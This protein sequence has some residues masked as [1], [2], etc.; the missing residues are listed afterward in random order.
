M[1]RNECS[2]QRLTAAAPAYRMAMAILMLCA[3]CSP[4]NESNDHGRAAASTPINLEQPMASEKDDSELSKPTAQ[5][6]PSGKLT[7]G[8]AQRLR[9]ARPDTRLAVIVE[10]VTARPKV[11][12]EPHKRDGGTSIRPKS[13]L[14]DAESTTAAGFDKAVAYF[15]ARSWSG[16]APVYIKAASAISVDVNPSELEDILTQP[17]VRQVSLNERHPLQE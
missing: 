11:R 13:L 6:H 10:V 14:V 3:A 2:V 8:L 5:S 17:F 15:E 9:A 16:H 12:F 7:A 4:A 1:L